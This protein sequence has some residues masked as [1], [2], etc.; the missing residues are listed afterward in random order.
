[1]VRKYLVRGYGVGGYAFQGT[2]SGRQ[3]KM[4][5]SSVFE[6]LWGA[7]ASGKNSQ[8]TRAAAVQI[9]PADRL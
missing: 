6:Q 1:V 2:G 5:P 4:N 9:C 8:Q 7:P 3:G